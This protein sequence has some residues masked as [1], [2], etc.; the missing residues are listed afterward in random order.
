MRV[1]KFQLTIANKIT[2]GFMAV[3]ALLT[4]VAWIAIAQVSKVDVYQ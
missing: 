3:L 2:G 4:I 1:S